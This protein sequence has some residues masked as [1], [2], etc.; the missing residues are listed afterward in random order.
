MKII[1]DNCHTKYSIADKKLTKGKVFK[2]KCKKCGNVIVVKPQ[3]E[4]EEADDDATRVVDYSAMSGGNEPKATPEDA[5]KIWHV[6][7]NDNQEGPFT[8]S[9][10]KAKAALGEITRDTF[11]WR[12]GLDDWKSIYKID[13]F[14]EIFASEPESASESVSEPASEPASE[15]E[16]PFAS[17]DS[18]G[19]FGGDEKDDL[20]GSE[21][22]DENL[23][24]M[25]G[26]RHENSVLFSLDNLQNLAAGKKKKKT[27]RPGYINPK[28]K[29]SGLVDIEE[30]ASSI[31]TGSNQQEEDLDLPAAPVVANPLTTAPVLNPAA[32]PQ[33][34]S[35]SSSGAPAPQAKKN[36]KVLFIGLG[37]FFLAA[38]L[39]GGFFIFKSDDSKEGSDKK[40]TQ[41]AQKNQGDDKDKVVA[42]DKKDA[43][44]KGADKKDADKKTSDGKGDKVDDADKKDADKKDAD[45][46][47]ADK[48]DA[49]KKDADKKDAD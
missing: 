32:A 30:M 34:Q 29:G 19:A 10:I 28:S 1:C 35:P 13:E 7:I 14:S 45:K 9:E 42:K 25:K 4:E 46:K 43:D 41:M 27:S 8:I 18:G 11:T 33:M 6:V 40:S 24:K 20:F 23:P 47:D 17:F 44:K 22:E 49:D 37:V 38:L 2:I 31:S 36:N 15:P 21:S 26:Q 5:A 39:V 16:D 48:K 3:E 12:E